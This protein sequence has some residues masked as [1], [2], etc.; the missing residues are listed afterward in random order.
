DLD[1]RGPGGEA[2]AHGGDQQRHAEPAPVHGRAEQLA[3]E[4]RHVARD[5]R[6]DAAPGR[7][8][9]GPHTQAASR[10]VTFSFKKSLAMKI[11]ASLLM[12]LTALLAS[13]VVPPPPLQQQAE[14]IIGRP[15]TPMS[16][17]GVARRTTRRAVYAGAAYGA[18]GAYA[19][20]YPYYPY[21]YW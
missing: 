17:A 10:G 1:R 5:V 21:P 4:R 11:I 2:A 15:L 14:G 9:V 20:P 6:A 13:A 18:Y 7:A 12:A 3:A 19:Q 16:F 8:P